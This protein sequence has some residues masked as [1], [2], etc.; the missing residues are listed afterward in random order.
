M[1][2][3]GEPA[4]LIKDSLVIADLHIGLG[5][6]LWKDGITI[7][8]QAKGMKERI[9]G[10]VNRTGAKE[11][12][13]LGDV[14][15][16]VP[17]LSWEERREIPELLEGLDKQ[18]KVVVVPGNHDDRIQSLIDV[19][20]APA[21]G[22]VRQEYGLLHGHTKPGKSLSKCKSLLIGHNHPTVNFR[23]DL[24]TVSSRQAWVVGTDGN[25]E[26]ILMPHFNPVIGGWPVN[27]MKSEK[28]LLGP[29]AKS[30]D[31]NKAK[32]FLLDGTDLG[33]VKNLK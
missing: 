3:K 30:I 17:G 6:D 21:T 23:D 15:H 33:E 13:V 7:P 2:V 29:M 16:K 20:V 27:E 14:K 11:L 31:L 1:F 24:G 25:R 10:L 4:F 8:D 12:V 9:L 18:V 19:E 26:I 22:I 5:Y 32:A 28:D